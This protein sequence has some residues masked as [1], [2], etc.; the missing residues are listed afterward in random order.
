M[1]VSIPWVLLLDD[2]ELDDVRA[3]LEELGVD[4][5]QWNKSDLVTSPPHPQHLLVTTAAHAISSG[6]RRPKTRD[7]T[8]AIWIAVAT[9]N[10]KS[11]SSAIFGA[12]F[13]YM[14][15]RPAH[16]ET[17]R[18]L[19][20][21][22][23]YRGDEHRLK[24]RVA[25]GYKISFRVN[26]RGSACDALLMDLSPGGCRLLTRRTLQPGSEL[27]LSFPAELTGAKSFSH[28]GTVTRAG[29]GS[30]AGGQADE[31]CIGVRFRSFDTKS[32]QPMLALLNTLTSGPAVMPEA[33][34]APVS[35]PALPSRAPRGVYG[36]EVAIFGLDNC[37]L[38]GR[39][40]SSRGIRVDPHP[41]LKID[42]T[43]RLA[44][45]GAGDAKQIMVD[46]R[47]IRDDGENGVALHFD[48][49]EP[50]SEESLRLLIERL[51]TIEAPTANPKQSSGIVLTSVISK[52][53]RRR[54]R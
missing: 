4:F 7:P 9:G 37:I 2:G 29:P 20:R 54:R 34:A 13:D 16:P 49:V 21:G 22:A 17:F 36:E 3:V 8:R 51:P 19:L 6:L 26:G 24:R 41:A 32:R 18:S 48:W 31:S 30:A 28:R 47:V 53:L 42:S 27:D 14:V 11:Q 10:S 33:P 43:L 25:V 46:A 1:M 12:G 5:D 38:I 50:R 40:L 52:I 35:T 44:L 45:A 15:K 39:D 23:L